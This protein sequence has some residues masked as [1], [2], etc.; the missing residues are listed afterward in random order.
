M[1]ATAFSK[2]LVDRVVALGV[3]VTETQVLEFLG[4]R[5]HAEPVGNGGKDI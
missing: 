1:I 4:P 2:F 3:Q 5:T